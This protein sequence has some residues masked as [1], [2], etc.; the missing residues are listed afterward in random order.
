MCVVCYSEETSTS[1][2][3]WF[4]DVLNRLWTNIEWGMEFLT[5]SVCTGTF[6]KRIS[7][8]IFFG[9]FCGIKHV[10]LLSFNTF[11]PSIVLY[12]VLVLLVINWSNND[13]I[14]K[15]HIRKCHS[16]QLFLRNKT[17]LSTES[18]SEWPATGH[19]VLLSTL[20]WKPFHHITI[21]S[22]EK[23]QVHWGLMKGILGDQE[24]I[25]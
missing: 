13:S 14:I 1:A 18:R 22:S 15:K 21:K 19:V 24:I 10:S 3:L 20:V 12:C 23:Q 6:Y 11:T 25:N 17:V 5:D 16:F 4:T 8:I 9:S 2:M 7:I